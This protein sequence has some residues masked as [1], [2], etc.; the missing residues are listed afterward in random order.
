MPDWGSALARAMST[1]HDRLVFLDADGTL[2]KPQLLSPR[3]FKQLLDVH[4]Q[5]IIDDLGIVVDDN[6]N[7]IVQIAPTFNPEYFERL[8]KRGYYVV[9][10]CTSNI[11]ERAEYGMGIKHVAHALH[12]YYG[13]P[14]LA[15]LSTRQVPDFSKHQLLVGFLRTIHNIK[16]NATLTLIDDNFQE[17]VDFA[18]HAQ[19]ARELAAINFLL[20]QPDIR[21]AFDKLINGVEN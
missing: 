18:K 20:A 11:Y 15:V 5:E 13:F 16:S 2:F 17:Q 6:G 1:P 3:D 9:G 21:V 14:N 4:G 10:I 12:Q 8:E 19:E 7:A